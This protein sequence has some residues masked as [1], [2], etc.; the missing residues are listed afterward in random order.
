MRTLTSLQS[1]PEFAGMLGRL[2][3]HVLDILYVDD[4]ELYLRSRS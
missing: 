4:A 3:V 1:S 2:H